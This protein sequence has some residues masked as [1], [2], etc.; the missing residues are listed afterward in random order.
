MN[1]RMGNPVE[2][3][4]GV[5]LINNS[6]S[7]K[8]GKTVRSSRDGKPNLGSGQG[9]QRKERG[10]SV[11]TLEDLEEVSR[12]EAMALRYKTRVT[13]FMKEVTDMPL[14]HHDELR[15][16]AKKPPSIV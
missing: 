4:Y 5:D 13:R 12:R 16:K 11:D 3:D 2:F 15:K 9:P 10:D 14:V 6:D 7:T 1:E 8:R